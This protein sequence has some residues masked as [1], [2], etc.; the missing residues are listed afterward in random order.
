MYGLNPSSKYYYVHS[1]FAP[2]T[3]GHLEREGWTVATARYGDETYIGA[4][5]R[6]NTFATQ[7]HPEKSG[8]AG[9]RVIKAFLD[10]KKV[11]PSMTALVPR[12]SVPADAKSG[13]AKVKASTNGLTRRIIACLDVR[14]N[15][16]GDLVVTKGDQYDVREKSE[17][18]NV[19][20]LGKPVEMARKYYTQ[21]ADE[22]TFLNITSFRDC[23]ITDLP[24]LEILRRTSETV[25]VPLTIGGGIRDMVDP[26]SGQGVSALDVAKLYFA[27]GADKVSIGS[28]AVLAAE[29][30][31]SRGGSGDGKTS[32][33]T[34]S[35]AY[36]AQA[37]VVSV[38]PKRVYVDAEDVGAA[39]AKGHTV[40][41]TTDTDGEGREHVWFACTIKG[42]REVR[43]FDVVKLVTACEKLGAGE[44]LLNAIDRDG[45]NRGFD[46]ELVALVKSVVEIPVI[47]S[48]GAGKPA[49]FEEVFNATDVDAALGAG[50]VSDAT[51]PFYEPSSLWFLFY[52]L[53][54]L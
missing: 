9:L 16:A 4:V 20:N 50:M 37:V 21:G 18:G 33:E 7:F 52:S 38:D 30:F 42:G 36:G 40:I 6:G 46:L 25:F 8:A 51:S 1:Y 44:V 13:S 47:A 10:G 54:L 22:V 29:A 41:K 24:M 26:V 45:S 14:T 3:P 53:F 19:R 49:H 27:S 39:K 2:Y 28:D 32:I 23:P 5:A 11:T 15:D 35:A 48:S 17:G 34:I 12:R 31:W 43:D